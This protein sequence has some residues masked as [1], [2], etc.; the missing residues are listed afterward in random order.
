VLNQL[1]K[2]YKVECVVYTARMTR[3]FKFRVI[4]QNSIMKQEIRVHAL[5]ENLFSTCY[6]KIV[7]L[8]VNQL[9]VLRWF[10]G[11]KAQSFMTSAISV[12]P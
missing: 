8:Q 6:D 11:R 12:L 7:R 4:K 3:V 2:K 5:A 9:F 1:I 10:L